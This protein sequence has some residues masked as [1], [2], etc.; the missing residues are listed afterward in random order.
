MTHQNPSTGGA[1]PAAAEERE[2]IAP[3]TGRYPLASSQIALLEDQLAFP[4]NTWVS[5]FDIVELDVHLSERQVRNLL[6]H[7]CRS[8]EALR[9]R[10]LVDAQGGLRQQVFGID[11]F[12]E[13]SFRY[14]GALT[15]ADVKAVVE[16]RLDAFVQSTFFVVGD[17]PGGTVLCYLAHHSFFDGTAMAALRSAIIRAAR[18]DTV[19]NAPDQLPH[20]PT[21]VQPRQVKQYEDQPRGRHNTAK[22]LE[23]HG[24]RFTT[25]WSPSPAPHPGEIEIEDSCAF[26]LGKELFAALAQA[27]TRT[28][29]TVPSLLNSLVCAYT[30]Q[31]FG[32]RQVLLKTSCSNRFLPA[33]RDSVT[34]LASEIWVLREQGAGDFAERHRSFHTE[35]SSAYR[36]GLYDWDRVRRA[37]NFRTP[38]RSEQTV[39]TNII[40]GGS[41]D[42]LPALPR[43]YSPRRVL[44]VPFALAHDLAIDIVHSSHD[45]R[46]AVKTA[47]RCF[48]EEAPQ[49]LARG[50]HRYIQHD[51]A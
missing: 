17:G 13:H 33:L 19:V 2:D 18:D 48:A 12:F 46:I 38:N 31:E 43:T 7:M 4:E 26:D 21:G 10:V 25:P 51:L 39:S 28:G 42:G 35:L 49:D 6:T 34:C 29:I 32:L 15:E 30:G 45:A 9:S 1:V 23:L 44:T 40:M 36:N 47:R 50:L 24:T 37:P 3:E 8:Y 41:P 27:A 20:T 14:L 16:K 11:H 22:W 5:S